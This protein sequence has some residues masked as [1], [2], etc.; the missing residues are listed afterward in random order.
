MNQTITG[1][2]VKG[3]QRGRELGFPTINVRVDNVSQLSTGVYAGFVTVAEEKHKAA[4]FIGMPETFNE[5]DVQVEA[6][7]LDFN[8]ELYGEEASVELV[9]KIRGVEQFSNVE[10]LK[11]QI[12]KDCVQI[13]KVLGGNKE[14]GLRQAQ[15]L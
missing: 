4:I 11:E 3:K 13:R 9:E 8:G 7:L 5:K 1:K 15:P 6:H 10:K 12:Q 14:D 2:I